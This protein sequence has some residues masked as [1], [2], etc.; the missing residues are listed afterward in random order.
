MDACRSNLDRRHLEPRH[1]RSQRSAEWGERKRLLA[2]RRNEQGVD[3]LAKI[4]GC[5]SQ[6]H[7]WRG[8]PETSKLARFGT[9]DWLFRKER[10]SDRTRP[11][12]EKLA[13]MVCDVPTKTAAP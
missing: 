2:L 5:A 4:D 11:D 8:Q 7:Q 3:L 12:Y 10:V 9:V 1:Q 13:H 6:H